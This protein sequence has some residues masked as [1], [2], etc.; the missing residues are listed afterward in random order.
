M[1]RFFTHNSDFL[2]TYKASIQDFCSVSHESKFYI[3]AITFL[4]TLFTLGVA[5]L[6]TFRLVTNHFFTKKL[7]ELNRNAVTP[8]E[9]I[10]PDL[11]PTTDLI[12]LQEL[13]MIHKKL[14]S[15]PRDAAN[16]PASSAQDN[17]S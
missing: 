6:P 12:K 10:L 2:T 9:K 11:S 16:C 15:T 1:S 4:A 14:P 5:T 3:V 17:D 7:H 8:E 13:R